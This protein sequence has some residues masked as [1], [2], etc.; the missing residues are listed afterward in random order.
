MKDN[1]DLKDFDITKFIKL[2][3]PARFPMKYIYMN[4]EDL[5]QKIEL[6]YD[7]INI[8]RHF[9]RNRHITY[10][11]NKGKFVGEMDFTYYL[12]CPETKALKIEYPELFI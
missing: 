11:S 12:K 7:K 2:S 9:N 10:Y 1:R 6:Y 8:E 3:N 5:L 4:F